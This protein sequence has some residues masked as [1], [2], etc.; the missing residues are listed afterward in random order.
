MRRNWLL[1][2]IL[3]FSLLT[4]CMDKALGARFPPHRSPIGETDNYIR[5]AGSVTPAVPARPCA[6]PRSGSGVE[7]AAAWCWQALKMWSQ[8]QN[9]RIHFHSRGWRGRGT[10]PWSNSTCLRAKAHCDLLPLRKGPFHSKSGTLLAW[11]MACKSGGNFQKRW[12]TE[13]SLKGHP[14]M[15]ADSAGAGV[16]G[17]ARFLYPGNGRESLETPFFPLLLSGGGRGAAKGR[18]QV[19]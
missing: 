16:G 15:T 7:A 4:S 1:S 14:P 17:G 12:W 11:K 9:T 13:G 3:L 10:Q 5:L 8:G 18:S 19:I 6:R 2:L